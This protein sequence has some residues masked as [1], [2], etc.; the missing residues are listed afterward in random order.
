MFPGEDLLQEGIAAFQAGDRLQARELLLEV[1]KVDPENEQAWYYLAACESDPG[2]RKEYL[3]QVL[4]INPTNAKARE[5]LD[6]IKSRESVNS[7]APMASPSGSGSGRS[8]LRALDPELDAPGASIDEPGSFRI[9]VRIPGAPARTTWERLGRD[10]V[11]L[12]RVGSQAA[13]RTPNAHADEITNATWWRFWLIAGVAAV[14]AGI[15]SFVNAL[16]LQARYS[17]SLFNIIGVLLTPFLFV[18][19][20]L[21]TLFVGCYASYRYAQIRGGMGSLV[22]HAYTVAVVWAPILLINSVLRFVFNLFTPTGGWLATLG[23]WLWSLFLI[24][25]G[26]ER[27]HVFSD[28]RE[29]WITAGVMVVAEF[30]AATL[31]GI[32]FGGIFVGA[33]PFAF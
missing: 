31:L 16:W 11:S 18:A 14:G 2:K 10:G 4:E 12:L 19:F 26:F 30:V 15:L 22:S 7:D 21:I 20:A 9:P 27:L 5:V 25:E 3:Q 32:I 29:K 33:L 1:I 6:R 23:L 8:R 13:L 17:G 28:P 24:A